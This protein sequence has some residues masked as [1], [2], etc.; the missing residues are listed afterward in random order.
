MCVFGGTNYPLDEKRF[1]ELTVRNKILRSVT[2]ENNNLSQVHS[3]GV[4]PGSDDLF[5][6]NDPSDE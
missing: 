1:G 6:R 5:W 2:F 4:M 3:V